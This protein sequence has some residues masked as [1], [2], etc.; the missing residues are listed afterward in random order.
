MLLLERA[1]MADIFSESQ[2]QRDLELAEYYNVP[3]ATV[4]QYEIGTQASVQLYKDEDISL[5]SYEFI[6]KKYP[7]VNELNW[8]RT[9]SALTITR[10]A[11]FV[12]NIVKTVGQLR[13]KIIIDFGCGVG[14]HGIFC[15]QHGAVVDFLDVD[16]PLYNFAKWRVRKRGIAINKYRYPDDQ[17]PNK[18]Y[19]V[20]ICLDVL[21]H[22]ADPA[23]ALSNLTAALKSGGYLLL[24]VSTAVKPTSGHFSQAIDIWKKNGLPILAKNFNKVSDK[25]FCKK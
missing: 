17:L 8:L 16:G 24:E 11:K 14:S 18:Y 4:K 15:A 20:V 2:D 9:C 10:R 6:Y 22:I 1:T 21:E 12:A 25:L 19:D 23:A 5:P 13:N 7:Y 3:L